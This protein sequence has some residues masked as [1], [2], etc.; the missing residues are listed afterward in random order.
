MDQFSERAIPATLLATKPKVIAAGIVQEQ[1][2]VEKTTTIPSPTPAGTEI[3]FYINQLTNT[4]WDCSSAYLL[5]TCVVQLGN[6]SGNLLTVYGNDCNGSVLGSFYSLIQRMTVFAGTVNQTDDIQEVGIIAAYYL[7]L[8]MTKQARDGMAFLLGFTPDFEVNGGL[9]QYRLKGTFPMVADGDAAVGNQLIAGPPVLGVYGQALANNQNQNQVF[10]VAIP[11][12]GS[13]GLN[14][15]SMYYLGLGQTKLSIYTDSPANFLHFPPAYQ[16][17]T[18][19]AVNGAPSVNATQNVGG[20]II[21]NGDQFRIDRARLIANIIRLDDSVMQ[22]VIA[23]MQ[24]VNGA[25]LVTKCSSF[26]IQTQQLQA[27]V[28]NIQMIN[29]NIRRGS[30]KSILVTFNPNGVSTLGQANEIGNYFKKYGSINPGLGANTM[31][32]IEN[33]NYP[34]LGLNPT[35]FPADTYAYILENLGL[36]DNDNIKPSINMQNWLVAD[37][38]VIVNFGSAAGT[39]NIPQGTFTYNIATHWRSGSIVSAFGGAHGASWWLSTYMPT[40][41]ILE[42]GAIANPSQSGRD[43]FVNSNDFFL[44]FNLEDQPRPG[45]I[46]GKNTQNGSNTLVLNLMTP[47]TYV[48]TIYMIA[49]FDALLVHDFSSNNVYYVT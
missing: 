38:N 13:L 21:V 44:Y 15:P 31:L 48:Y 36:L 33:V 34:K 17:T 35:Q 24:P 6:R 1:L 4:F 39:N 14:N 32:Q 41:A 11:L 27:G 46:S 43:C 10:Q 2:V 16:V 47:T 22:K 30:I 12:I 19:V 40:D 5:L 18:A 9:C 8:T 45:M 28:S 42:D 26:N 49:L 29:M 3:Q 7:R 23:L 37:P 20:L 25:Q